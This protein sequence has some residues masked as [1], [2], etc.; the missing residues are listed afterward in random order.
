VIRNRKELKEKKRSRLV[1][2]AKAASK[3]FNE[4]SYTETSLEDIA[5]AGMSKGALYYYFPSK[6]RILFF[7]IDTHGA[8]ILDNLEQELEQIEDG[9]S[10][11]RFFVSRHIRL[12][13]E[14]MDESRLFVNE[15]NY[16]SAKYLRIIEDREKRYYKIAHS[17][18]SDLLG[19]RVTE[20]ELTTVTFSLFGMITWV[21]AWYD[22][23]GPSPP[24]ELSEI[25]CGIFLKGVSRYLDSAYPAKNRM[26]HAP[27]K[28]EEWND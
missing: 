8:R 12:Y 3:V 13:V 9:Y 25:I 22:P 19:N 27:V 4:K 2:I 1:R 23:T 11:I 24:Q 18:L 17:L 15:K 6:V 7:I 5:A 10:K 20:G 21:Y 16:L 26:G 28:M 14:N